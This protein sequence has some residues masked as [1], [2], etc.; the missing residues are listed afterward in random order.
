MLVTLEGKKYRL[1]TFP[2]LA[3]RELMTKGQGCKGILD[4][5]I[6]AWAPILAYVQ[7]NIVDDRWLPLSTRAMIDNHVKEK[8]LADLV[9]LQLQHNCKDIAALINGP[10]IGDIVAA[11][12]ADIISQVFE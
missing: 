7:V 2:V 12:L 9:L 5:G 10:S 1:S 4:K 11:E 3:G 8:Y 6:E